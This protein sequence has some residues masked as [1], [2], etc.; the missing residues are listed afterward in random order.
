MHRALTPLAAL[1]VA[2]GLTACAGARAETAPSPRAGARPNNQKEVEIKPYDEVITDQ[3]VTDSGLFIVHR[4]EDELYYEI[5]QELLEREML[6]VSRRAR[7]AANIGYGGEKNNTETVRWQRHE[8]KI[9]LRVVSY[10]NVADDSLPI[11]EAVRNSNF[12]PIVHAFD[13]AAFKMDTA[14]AGD[15]GSPSVDTAAAVI[16]VTPLFTTDVPILGLS[17]TTRERFKVQSLDKDRTFINWARSYPRNIEV[18]VVM[19]YSAQQPPSNASSGSISL[20]MNHS[21]ILLPETPMQARL[22]DERVGFFRV[23]QVDYGIS[24]QKTIT[25]RYITRWRLEPSDTAAF[26]RG[27][28]VEPVQPI[29]WYIDPATPEKWRPYLKQG[30]EDWNTAFA[31]AGFRN[32]IVAKDP[33][34]PE[35]DPEFSP[36]DVRYSVIRWFPSPIQNAYGPHVH[37]PRSG[38]ILESDIGWFHNVMNLLRNWY[39]VQTAAANPEAR[40]VKFD[41]EVM[42]QLIRFVAAHEVGH[43]L[44]L[45]HNMKASAS[46]PVDSLRSASFTCAMGTAPSIMDYARFNYVAQPEDEG[47]CFTPGIGPY[48]DYSIMWGYRPIPEAGS[49]DAER[50]TLDR[51]I[52]E[53]YDDPMYH[54]GDRSLIDPTS[55]TEA[56]G[57]DAMRASAYGIANLKRIVPNLVAWSYQELEDYAELEELYGQVLAQWNRYMGHV[58]TYI[59]GVVET[60]RTYGQG[61][62]VYAFVPEAD[63]R[64]AMAFLAE[65]AF[66]PPTWI[67]DE[68]ILRRIENVGTVERMRTLQVRVVNLVL[69]PGRMQRLIENEARNGSSAYSLGEMLGD[70]RAAVWSELRSGRS[71]D[72]YR[73]NLQRGYLERLEWLMTEEPGPMPSVLRSSAT[74]VN[75]PQSD[76]RPY[77]RGELE[78]LKREISQALTRRIDRST[79]IHLADALVRIERIL[80]PKD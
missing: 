49:P 56:I 34:S 48:D 51:W 33:P 72:V 22:W 6:I 18:R 71:I 43:T 68:D 31:A 50:E 38:E 3:A 25:R 28:L 58:A 77:V 36:E 30:V 69:D 9:L 39:L 55:Q 5:P 47:V 23:Q 17:R 10:S 61:G 7:T 20:E 80:D 67:I 70:L 44:G 65:Q 37:D 46:Y 76:I 29:T 62:D 73:R 4:I 11:Y 52:R 8:G 15:A 27:E 53:R 75:L 59:G 21:M 41:D 12:E 24:D 60:R 63:Q 74:A 19:T 79:W 40:G 13:I 1:L 66:T 78:A 2:V 42:G 35:E 57:D 64:R 16:E 45:P 32:A 26:L 54:F 14:A